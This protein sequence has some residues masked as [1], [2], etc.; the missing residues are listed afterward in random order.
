MDNQE[1]P[2]PVGS[3]SDPMDCEATIERFR[4]L[5]EK[6]QNPMY[7]WMALDYCAYQANGEYSRHCDKPM[8]I[9]PWI[10][11]YLLHASCELQNLAC[12]FDER[13]EPPPVRG[14][15]PGEAW[16]DY[17][18]S[19]DWKQHA[20]ARTIPLERAMKLVPFALQLRRTGWSA[21]SSLAATTAKMHEYRWY[22]AARAAG[23]P[24]KQALHAIAETLGLTE[25]R[26]VS[27]RIEEGRDLSEDPEVSKPTP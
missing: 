13:I 9:P 26:Y 11:N 8:T 1:P 17:I 2:P 21:F 12:G 18:A 15:R 25:T 20:A 19:D 22:R 27:R 10:A 14:I 5:A 3:N 16:Q 23:I 24:A 4:Q 7:V 6:T